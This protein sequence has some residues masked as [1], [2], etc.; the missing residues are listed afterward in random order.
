MP[1]TADSKHNLLDL[2]IAMEAVLKQVPRYQQ[3][4]EG[5]P[6]GADWNRFARDV[7]PD[8]TERIDSESRQALLTR[9]PMREIFVDRLPVYDEDTPDL[10]GGHR[11][12][13]A[14][15]RLVLA[16]VRVRNNLVHG[17]KEDL[18]RERH[19]GHDQAVVDAAIEV[20]T[21]AQ[22]LLKRIT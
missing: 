14:G 20:L 21:H 10:A 13:T 9:P 8:L 15:A 2:F 4:N 11:W 12:Q 7:G 19:Q 6:A 3:G 5:D 1:V 17:G 22:R 16:S 18:D